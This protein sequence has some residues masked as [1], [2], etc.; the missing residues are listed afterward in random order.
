MQLL[1]YILTL[2]GDWWKM[3]CILDIFSL[4]CK[5]CIERCLQSCNCCPAC[6][7]SVDETEPRPK[8]R[9]ELLLITAANRLKELKNHQF[10]CWWRT[11]V[12]S[13]SFL[14]TQAKSQHARHGQQVPVKTWGRWAL[15]FL[16]LPWYKHVFKVQNIDFWIKIWKFIKLTNVSQRVVIILKVKQI[17]F[18]V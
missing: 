8:L 7:E 1:I 9:Y 2:Q 10:C 18:S 14:S 6:G 3:L 16:R 12:N 5:E 17:L 15:I 13:S 4:V 11:H